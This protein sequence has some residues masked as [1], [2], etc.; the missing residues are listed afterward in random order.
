MIY[1]NK[2]LPY[3]MSVIPIAAKPRGQSNTNDSR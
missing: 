1:K 3:S 2:S